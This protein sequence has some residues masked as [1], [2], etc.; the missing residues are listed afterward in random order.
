[1][2]LLI[3]EFYAPGKDYNGLHFLQSGKVMNRKVLPFVVGAPRDSVLVNSVLL[4][5]YDQAYFRNIHDNFYGL[6]P[7]LV[8]TAAMPEESFAHAKNSFE[9]RYSDSMFGMRLPAA[10][11][12]ES[13]I[14]RIGVLSHGENVFETYLPI[15]GEPIGN[16]YWWDF[17]I[18]DRD[19]SKRLESFRLGKY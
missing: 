12:E 16:N 1:M 6:S 7:G 18:P 15:K 4:K 5:Y 2:R 8:Y 10:R 19:F 9:R 17:D 3:A 11:N 14:L 13:R